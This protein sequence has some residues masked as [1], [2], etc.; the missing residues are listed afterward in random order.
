MQPAEYYGP[1]S[2]DA[3]GVKVVLH[4]QHEWPEVENWGIDITP[5]YHTNIK[6]K[7]KKVITLVLLFSIESRK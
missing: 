4:E 5:G 2:Y 3:T 6:I 7:R 1:F